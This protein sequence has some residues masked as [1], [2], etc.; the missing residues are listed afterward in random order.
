MKTRT[1]IIVVKIEENLSEKEIVDTFLSLLKKYQNLFLA[2]TAFLA[3]I[4]MR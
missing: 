4:L 2:L 3:K 1:I